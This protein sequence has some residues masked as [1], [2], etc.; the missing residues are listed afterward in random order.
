MNILTFLQFQRLKN[1]KCSWNHI[2]TQ[3][4]R[5]PPLKIF[6]LRREV[7]KTLF[8]TPLFQ[9]K[10]KLVCDCIVVSIGLP[11]NFVHPFVFLLF[12]CFN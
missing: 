2:I 12:R 5:Q 11:N 10:R 9:V 7:Y 4:V 3:I 8:E 6:Y 1:I